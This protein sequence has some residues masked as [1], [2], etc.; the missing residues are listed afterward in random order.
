MSAPESISVLRKMTAQCKNLLPELL[1]PPRVL[2]ILIVGLSQSLAFSH[3]VHARPDEA[4]SVY[5]E[6][7]RHYA[8]PDSF[9]NLAGLA[10]DDLGCVYLTVDSPMESAV[11]KYNS[12][13]VALWI[14]RYQSSDIR[15]GSI[16]VD[17][18]GNVYMAGTANAELSADY[19][20]IKYNSSGKEEWA[21]RYNGPDSLSDFASDLA[22]D[23]FG[24]I[25]VTGSSRSLSAFA[26]YATVKYNS[27]G[28]QRWA[29]RYNGRGPN[30][31]DEASRITIDNLG[32]IYITGLSDGAD[33]SYD[34]A[35]IKYN[36]S[37]IEQ[38]VSRYIGRGLNDDTVP[39]DLGLDDLGNTYV[40]GWVGAGGSTKYATVKYNA[41]GIEQWVSYFGESGNTSDPRGGLALDKSGNLYV[42][43]LSEV[44]DRF[45]DYLT[46]KYNS[47]DGVE[48]WNMRYNG[49]GNVGDVATSIAVD[50]S[51][52]IYVTG[53]SFANF[54]ADFT[55]LKYDSDGKQ[56]W[57]T[58]YN[59]PQNSQDFPDLVTV[60]KSGNIYIAGRSEFNGRM[61]VTLIK[62]KQSRTVGIRDAKNML[63]KFSLSQNYPNPFNPSTTIQYSIG[64][65]GHVTLKVFNLQG[66]EIITLVDA[67]KQ[68]GEHFVEWNPT[69]L[70]S[71]VY[72]YRLQSKDLTETKKLILLR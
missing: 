47:T 45:G 66:Q 61:I 41:Q 9:S 71:G 69:D 21:A 16:R 11:I 62:Y 12:N 49:L 43:G 28:V 25:V 68:A 51:E 13:G 33:G 20:T 72:L 14:V 40:T 38:W 65:P 56:V 6:W 48:Q 8:G 29:S 30:S 67:K 31:R 18:L 1:S 64:K 10:V 39:S 37:G 3:S 5:S 7:T 53:Y 42:T 63:N 36:T 34:W 23:S 57:L 35:T 4:D 22:I 2:V 24:D 54:N 52:Y 19:I 58:S 60:D 15:A 27:L 50:N 46:V 70:P 17:N 32:N 26:D 55:T 44:Y 59:G